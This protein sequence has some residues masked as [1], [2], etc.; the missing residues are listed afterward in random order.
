M[1]PASVDA[2]GIKTVIFCVFLTLF[3]DTNK[4][5]LAAT[6]MGLLGKPNLHTIGRDAQ[7]A[8]TGI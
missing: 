2:G 8:R 6:R 5:R 7:H 1:P 4:Y 3:L